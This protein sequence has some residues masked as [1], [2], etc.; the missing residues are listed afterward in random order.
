MMRNAVK[1][2]FALALSLIVCTAYAAPSLNPDNGHFYEIVYT[3]Y[4]N[5]SEAATAAESLEF[6]GIQGHLVSITSAQE[7]AFVASLDVPFGAWIG[8]LQSDNLDEPAG[9]WTWIDGE[10]WGY[11]NWSAGEPNDSGGEDCAQW[12]EADGWNDMQCLEGWD[13]M[14]VEYDGVLRPVPA[15]S[16][17]MLLALAALLFAVGYTAFKRRQS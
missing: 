6:G 12:W 16:P 8:G 1:V 15:L 17:W 3:G 11:T 13:Y 2:V 4:L 14:V 9:N 10:P 7:Q 5:F